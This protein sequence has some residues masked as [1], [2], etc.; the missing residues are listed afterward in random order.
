MR[1]FATRSDG[2]VIEPLGL[3]NFEAAKGADEIARKIALGILLQYEMTVVCVFYVC[4]R[5]TL[6]RRS[7]LFDQENPQF[8]Y[9]VT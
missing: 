9:D 1:R 8:L 2:E 7:R 5:L 3:G 6:A 4:H